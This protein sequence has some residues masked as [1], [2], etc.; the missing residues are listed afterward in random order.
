[1]YGYAGKVLRVDLS[2]EQASVEDLDAKAAEKFLGGR[3]YAA[4][5]LYEETSKGFDP[6]GN[7]SLLVFMTGPAT[8]TLVPTGN[9][10]ALVFKS[11]LTGGF[12]HSTVG[13]H[14]G[15]ELKFAGYDG[16]VV[17]GRSSRPV[18]LWINDE[19]A[20]IRDAKDLWGKNTFETELKIRKESNDN[21]MRVASIGK[22]GE[23]LCAIANVTVDFYRSFG[24]GGAGAVMG[25]KALK[26]MAIKGARR[27]I[28]VPDIE[29]LSKHVQEL[30]RKLQ[31]PGWTLPKYGTPGMLLTANSQKVL[32]TRNFQRT[33]FE[34][35]E[36]IGPEQIK[37]ELVKK[38]K[39]CYACP[40]YC[41]KFSVVEEGP[42]KSQAE[43]PEFETLYALGSCCG[44]SNLKAVLK[45]NML[46]DMHG[47]DTMSLGVTISFAMECYERGLLNQGDMDGL[48]L[49]W[50]N[51]DAMLTLI[52]RIAD[53]KGF[54]G[55][56]ADGVRK[57]AERIGKNSSAYAMH[58]KGMELPGY[59]PRG[60]QG[61]GL[62][63]ATSNRGA[64]HSS[65]YVLT[66][67]LSGKVN[68]FETQGKGALA[69]E[70]Q[71]LMAVLDS[72][73]ICKFVRYAFGMTAEGYTETIRLVTGR[74]VD[75]AEVATIG[76]R[77]FNIERMFN[78]REGMGRAEDTLPRRFLEEPADVGAS[79]PQ[80][81]RLDEMLDDYYV[82][83]GYD[84]QGRPTKERLKQ[85][86]LEYAVKDLE[87]G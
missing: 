43:G 17:R 4:K 36:K 8:G 60:L 56:L 13:G 57:A 42:Y 25:S 24:R 65:H 61:T 45:A 40:V 67:E 14:F 54:G 81:V 41:G 11:P 23:S 27:G 74:P 53:K 73:V 51:A 33:S 7:D 48:D 3:G 62:G 12:A 9:R 28:E 77:I 6:L 63:Y 5:V 55:V 69:K 16:I 19:R 79:E 32:P 15:P 10:T 83:R 82:N 26:A 22:A 29:A 47:L 86:G 85:L 18:Y 1:M 44:N 35:I 31:I 78:L 34:E 59:D 66:P 87:A 75:S 64:C 37:K 38:D 58:V 71:D 2:R 68:R 50:G 20:E 46:S 80:V 70:L 21:E 30:Y 52:D 84:K 49:S 76:E 39:A 72:L